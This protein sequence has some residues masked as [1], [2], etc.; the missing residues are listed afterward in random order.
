MRRAPRWPVMAALNGLAWFAVIKG[1]ALIAE[2]LARL[3]GR[4]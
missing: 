1:G 4:S 2:A 3:L